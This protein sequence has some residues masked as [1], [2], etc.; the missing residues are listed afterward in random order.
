M[1]KKEPQK[2]DPTDERVSSAPK[3]PGV[4]LMKDAGGR[5]MYVGK[6]KNLR[7]RVQSYFREKG[8]G[9][10]SATA[11]RDKVRAVEYVATAN[12]KEALLLEDKLIKQYQ[13]RYN[14]DLKDDAR[15][16]SVKVTIQDDFPRM[17][18]V[19]QRRDDG[20]LYFGPFPSARNAR[21]MVGKLQDKYRL[22]RCKGPA[23]SVDG[24]CLYAQIDGC[25][26]PCAG[27]ISRDEYRERVKKAMSFLRHAEQT[28]LQIAN[29]KL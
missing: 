26:S 25:A 3:A 4:Y 29:C 16:A 9:R 24:P 13:P 2:G 5:V 28:E 20:A 18:V 8:D 27:G 1:K 14:V 21:K 6:A 23:P 12:E 15:Y 10:Y 11:L 7:T 17:F 19:H 22:R